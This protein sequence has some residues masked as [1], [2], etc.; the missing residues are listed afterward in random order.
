[1]TKYKRYVIKK[2]IKKYWV[3]M[4]GTLAFLILGITFMLIGFN[5]TGWSLIDWLKS[6]YALTCGILLSAF[7][8][9]AVAIAITIKRHNLGD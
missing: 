5:M 9:G 4:A 7:A 3:A 8:V 1:M 2:T 6:P